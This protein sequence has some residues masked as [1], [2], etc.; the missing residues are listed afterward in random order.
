MPHLTP[1]TPRTV[2][3]SLI[4]AGLLGVTSVLALA[5]AHAA[6]LDAASRVGEVTLYPDAAIVKRQIKLD[7]PAG[8]HE[9]QLFDLPASLDPAS[10]RVDGSASERV[11]IGN[12][13]FRTRAIIPE[14]DKTE[15]QRK[16]KSLRVERD[17]VTDKVDAAENRKAMIQRLA[18]SSSGEGKDGKLDLDQWTKAL[19]LVGKNLQAVNDELRGLRLEIERIDGEI[20][21]LEPPADRIRPVNRDIKRVATIAVEAT[22]ATSLTLTIS[23]RV[24]GAGWRPI[25]DARLDTRGTVPSLELTRRAMIRQ[26]TGE[27]WNEAKLT[28]STLSV[29]R[30]TAAPELIGEKIGFYERPMP[31]VAM[32][33]AAPAPQAA[34]NMMRDEMEAASRQ[35]AASPPARAIEEAAAQVDAGA[36]QTEF[37]VPGKVT[38][39]SGGTEKSI[40]LGVE[41]PEPKVIVRTA[42]VLDPTAYLEASFEQGGEAP[43][44]PG[45]VLLSRDGAYIGR[46]RLPLI[47]PGDSAKLGFGSDDRIKVARVPASRKTRD[48]GFLGSTKSDKF[49]FRTTVKNLHGFPVS[50]VI[51][52]RVPVSEDQSITVERMAEMSKPDAEA[53]ED[54]RG[55]V[56]W[57]PTL[58]PQEEKTYVTAYRLRWPANKETRLTPLPR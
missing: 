15:T 22:A 24:S 12:V 54:R 53:P 30:G 2:T 48:P 11:V 42:P 34:A 19:D 3:K 51:E 55:V 50:V 40:R 8:E 18:Q 29:T 13:D 6:S 16:V 14:T 26:N 7:I 44:L 17:R 4:R 21:A 5:S 58:K 36:Y 56:V 33:M 45:E 28:L 46:G 10:L 38:V 31:R 37:Q 57:T 47:A 9:I 52:D 35:K 41:K 1:A 27:D 49:E 20:A 39:P 43:I 25:Y 32:P 23:Y